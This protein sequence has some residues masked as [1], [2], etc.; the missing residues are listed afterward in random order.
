M[1]E[2]GSTATNEILSMLADNKNKVIVEGELVVI[3]GSL[4]AG[5]LLRQLIYWYPRASAI[6]YIAKTD[7]DFCSELYLSRY[8]LRKARGDL[9]RLNFLEAWAGTFGGRKA[10]IYAPNL[11]AIEIA[12]RDHRL[13]SD[14]EA[15]PLSEIEQSIVRKR[16]IISETTAETTLSETTGK[17][18]EKVVI[19]DTK[20][21]NGNEK[22]KVVDTNPPDNLPADPGG[23]LENEIVEDFIP[24]EK[25][26]W[27]EQAKKREQEDMLN[28]I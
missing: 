24:P 2:M 23:S 14:N 18:K 16:T 5:I 4:A 9:E 21:I 11:E 20:H 12:L 28:R 8:A 1:F 15:V 26:K 27:A 13:N 7:K 22:G 6:G 17:D 19:K 25:D 10:T 3:T